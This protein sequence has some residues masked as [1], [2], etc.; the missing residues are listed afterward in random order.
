MPI[1]GVRE[2]KGY[3]TGVEREVAKMNG[4]RIYIETSSKPLYEPTRYFYLS[5]GYSIEA[6][7][8]DFY[9]VNDHKVMFSR[10]V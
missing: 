1:I 5:N 3:S 10:A 7:L 8:K 9:D 6:T 4:R 2:L